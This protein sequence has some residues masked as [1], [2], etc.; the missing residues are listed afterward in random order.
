MIQDPSCVEKK[1]INNKDVESVKGFKCLGETAT[2][3]MK[4]KINRRERINKLNKFAKTTRN[5]YNI[6][7][8]S[9][10]DSPLCK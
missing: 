3:N 8:M 4:E 2:L 7:C 6:K 9:I 1:R 10:M 5:I